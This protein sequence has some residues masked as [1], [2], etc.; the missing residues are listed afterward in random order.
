M[1]LS[2]LKGKLIIIFPLLPFLGLGTLKPFT[3]IG[4]EEEMSTSEEKQLSDKLES[5]MNLAKE[6]SPEAVVAGEGI[7]TSEL[8]GSD[9]SGEGTYKVPYKTILQAMRR[10][11][12]EPFPIIY[13]DPKPDSEAAKSGI[14]LF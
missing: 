2:L 3:I 10:C 5:A 4:T 9:E 6:E 8:R 7:F 13:Q 14:C 12:K 11:G 1:L